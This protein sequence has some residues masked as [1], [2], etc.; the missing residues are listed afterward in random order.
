MELRA[1]TGLKASAAINLTCSNVT[2]YDFRISGWEVGVL[3][4]YN[5]NTIG[6]NNITATERGIAIYADDYKVSGNY[7]A[8]SIEGVR[9]KGNNITVQQNQI[10]NNYYWALITS[11]NGIVVTRNRIANNNVAVNTDNMPPS[12]LQI[13]RNNFFIGANDSI[14]TVTSDAMGFGNAGTMP[15]WDNGSVGNYWSDYAAKYP[16]AS[17]IGGKG[18]G[19]IPNLIRTYP[20]VIDRYPLLAPVNTQSTPATLPPASNPASSL[21][22]QVSASSTPSPNHLNGTIQFTVIAVLAIGLA[23]CVAV[24][25]LRNKLFWRK[26]R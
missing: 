20:T 21:S 1:Q 15:P 2:V 5:G 8:N 25:A 24:A 23:T 14:V 22:Q 3:G 12:N 9:I 18:I 19:D 26:R 7:L 4:V 17:E 10:A 13:Y 16:N 11:S 6:Y